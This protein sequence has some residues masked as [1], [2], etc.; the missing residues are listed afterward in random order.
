MIQL[1]ILLIVYT[2]VSFYRQFSVVYVMMM[3][4]LIESPMQARWLFSDAVIGKRV[5]IEVISKVCMYILQCTYA[6]R[7][8]TRFLPPPQPD[9]T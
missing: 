9:Q 5:I 6:I 1:M 8:H 2:H 3:L 7:P 4:N